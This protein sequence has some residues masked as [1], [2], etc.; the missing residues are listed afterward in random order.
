MAEEPPRGSYA[1][2]YVCMYF[3]SI[4][5]CGILVTLI[6]LVLRCQWITLCFFQISFPQC[7][8]KIYSFTAHA[9]RLRMRHP[10]HK[11]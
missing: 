9:V 7:R 3:Q 1:I 10:D 11:E 4:L 8:V 5:N 6:Y 2:K